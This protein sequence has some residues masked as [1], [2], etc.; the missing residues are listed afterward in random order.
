MVTAAWDVWR[1]G[2]WPDLDPDRRLELALDHHLAQM[3]YCLL[4]SDFNH[5]DANLRKLTEAREA[6]QGAL[7]TRRGSES[8]KFE[9]FL[10]AVIKNAERGLPTAQP[11]TGLP[12]LDGD[13]EPELTNDPH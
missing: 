9:A 2:T 3:A 11:A 1:G 10:Q 6:I 8:A 13:L 7:E 4:T 12:I 5:P